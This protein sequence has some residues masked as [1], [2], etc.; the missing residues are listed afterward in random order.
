M[1]RPAANPAPEV[2]RAWLW[3]SARDGM[4]G[5]CAHPREARLV[6]AWSVVNELVAG[7][8]PW[9]RPHGDDEFVEHALARL[10]VCGNGAQ[11]QRA[12]HDRAGRLADVLDVVA[13]PG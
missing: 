4:T 13:W 2:L 7:L 6:S 3:R 11:R 12:A 1:T 5:Q 10:R 8:Q 9:L